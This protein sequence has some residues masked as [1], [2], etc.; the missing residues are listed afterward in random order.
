MYIFKNFAF[1]CVCIFLSGSGVGTLVSKWA[2]SL[3]DPIYLWVFWDKHSWS[4]ELVVTAWAIALLSALISQEK[5]REPLESR[6]KKAKWKKNAQCWWLGL[7]LRSSLTSAQWPRTRHT[8]QLAYYQ[9]SMSP[10]F[11]L[12]Q[13]AS[14]EKQPGDA[15]GRPLQF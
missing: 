7:K 6:F 10:V 9:L 11:L 3:S 14:N 12:F 8:L 2:K 13:Q 5:R 4:T 15:T 1:L